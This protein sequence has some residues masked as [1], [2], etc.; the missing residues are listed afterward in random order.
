M[1][2]TWISPVIIIAF[3]VCSAEKRGAYGVTASC[4]AFKQRALDDHGGHLGSRPMSMRRLPGRSVLDEFFT[5]SASS[6]RRLC[7]QSRCWW[8]P[9]GGHRRSSPRGHHMDH[10]APLC[11]ASNIVG[12]D[13]TIRTYEITWIRPCAAWRSVHRRAGIVVLMTC[14]SPDF[15]DSGHRRSFL[16]FASSRTSLYSGASS[17][18]TCASTTGDAVGRR[19]FLLNGASI[20][21]YELSSF[22][23]R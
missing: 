1:R 5:F 23:G 2:R 15:E 12:V 13:T 3:K 14:R 11:N 21:R 19:I 18:S 17:L 20:R 9:T 8:L 10:L 4:F 7:A 6:N 16:S 22:A